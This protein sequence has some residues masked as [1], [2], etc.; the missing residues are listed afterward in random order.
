[1]HELRMLRGGEPVQPEVRVIRRGDYCPHTHVTGDTDSR[2]VVCD[3]C[4]REVD[5]FDV[6]INLSQRWEFHLRAADHA[7]EEAAE[8]QAEL[9]R[10][11]G[12]GRLLAALEK[13]RA[14]VARRPKSTPKNDR[15]HGQN[16]GPDA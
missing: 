11:Y 4:E 6:L 13:T 15:P 9:Q 12:A 8:A 2:R 3:D 1:M 16:G 5:P 7:R 10:V 14:K